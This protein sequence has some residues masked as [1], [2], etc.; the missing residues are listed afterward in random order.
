MKKLIAVLAI[1]AL[2]G[3]AYG[4]GI[5]VTVD[6]QN[7]PEVWTMEVYNNSGGVLQSGMVVVWDIDASSSPAQYTDRLMYVNTTV[8]A[9]DIW[10]AGVVVD[11]TIGIT[12]VGTIAIFGP[13]YTLCLDASFA[14]T[15]STLVGTETTAGCAGGFV[16][17][18]TDNAA[19]GVALA[20]GPNT[21]AN[22]GFGG[23]AA[24]DYVMIPIFVD[25]N[26]FSDN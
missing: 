14:V 1:L 16:G 3:I 18:G 26:R 5:P 6:P 22:G 25:V 7:S 10:T 13:V 8:T 15:V 24:A 9:D 2:T 19:L 11:N 20:S 12:S 17:T 23:T 21:V 4:A